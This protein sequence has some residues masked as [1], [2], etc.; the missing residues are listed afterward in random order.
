MV[1]VADEAEHRVPTVE[2]EGAVLE[3]GPF[4]GGVLHA[5]APLGSVGS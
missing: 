5:S 3:V 2:V 4:G 1:E